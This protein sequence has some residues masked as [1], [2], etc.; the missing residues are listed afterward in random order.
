MVED[1]FRDYAPRKGAPGLVYD[2]NAAAVTAEQQEARRLP[3]GDDDPQPH[4]PVRRHTEPV[5]QEASGNRARRRAPHTG[6]DDPERS[7]G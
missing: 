5:I 2:M 4:R 7:A 3:G 1:S 6:V